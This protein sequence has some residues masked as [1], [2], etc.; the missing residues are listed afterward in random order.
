[1]KP[2]RY[3]GVAL[4]A[5]LVLATLWNPAGSLAASVVIT[6][7]SYT[8]TSG[9]DGGQPVANL[10]VKDQSGSQ[11]NWNKYVEFTTPGS[12]TYAGYRSYTVPGGIAPATVTAIQV[13]ANFLGPAPADQ[14]WTWRIYDWTT[15]AWV[16][17]GTN[18]GASWDAWTLLTFN[19]T[20]TL[21]N[22]INSSTS[23][24]RIRLVSNNTS[25]NADL[26]YE[27]VTL[28]TSASGATATPTATRTATATA[29]RTPTAGPTSTP[30]RTPTTGR[31]SRSTSRAHP[32]ARSPS[33]ATLA[34]RP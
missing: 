14:T 2:I 20:G 32:A 11:N 3:V 1:M 24:I 27:A 25:D 15:S 19:A 10:Q 26:D 30:T 23:E 9:N 29:T 31:M 16:T 28:T 4:I 6:P 7:S 13:Q 21:V 8:T 12:A 33:R 22:Y 17:L 5:A 18:S 34:S